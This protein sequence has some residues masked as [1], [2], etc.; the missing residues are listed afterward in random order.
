MPPHEPLFHPRTI[1]RHLANAPFPADLDERRA[2]LGVWIQR[3][4][5]GTIDR[6]TEVSTDRSFL[7]SVFGQVLDYRLFDDTR[8]LNG[9]DLDTQE[10]PGTSLRS[11][12]GAIGWFSPETSHG[13]PKLHGVIEMKRSTQDLDTA[14]G[15]SQ[16]PVEQAWGYANQSRTARWIIVSNFR[17]TRLYC[18]QRTSAEYERFLLTDLENPEAFRRFWLLLSRESLLPPDHTAASRL[19][20][21]LVESEQE[22]KTITDA[23]Y[24]DYAQ[25]R[26]EI[27]EDLK[28]AH[29]NLPQIELVRSTQKILDRF[30][31]MAFAEDRGLLPKRVI[32]RALHA[33]HDF[34]DVPVWDT[35]KALARQID[36]GDPRRDIPHLNGGLFAEDPELDALEVPDTTCLRLARLA[37]YDFGED[38]SV[39]VLGHIFEQ[40][41]SDLEQL[42]AE[43]RGESIEGVGARKKHGVFYTPGFVTRFLVEQTVGVALAERFATC[44]DEVR[45]PLDPKKPKGEQVGI[46]RLLAEREATRKL[47]VARGNDPEKSDTLKEWDAR[48]DEAWVVAWESYKRSLLRFRVLDPACGS[49]AFLAAAFDRLAT[50]YR[51]VDREISVHSKGGPLQAGLFDVDETVLQ[52]NLFGVDLSDESV[53]ISRLSLWL[54]T[55]TRQRPLTWLDGNVQRGDSIVDDPS[56]SPHAFDWHEGNRAR[57][58]FDP[59]ANPR[60][61]EIHAR[62]KDGFDVVLGNPPYVRQEWITEIKPYL[63]AHY[64]AFDGVA[65]LFVY[66]FERGLK[67]LVPGGRLGFIVANKWLKGGYAKALRG[68]LA[69][70]CDVEQVIDFGH[71]PIF[72]DA[73][74]FPS[75]IVVRKR[76]ADE[77]FDPD[78][79]V[80]AVQFPREEL[81]R[82]TVAEFVADRRFSIPQRRLG[83]DPWSLEP[84]AVELLM[85]KLRATGV[86]LT[87]WSGTRPHY[88]VKTGFNEAFLVNQSTRD[89]LVQED[90]RSAEILKPYLRGQDVQR[91][92]PDWD[93]QFILAIGSS[94]DVAW[95]WAAMAIEADARASFAATYPAVHRHMST[96]EAKLRP[97]A[98]QGRWWWELRSCTY[99]EAFTRPKI[100]YQVIQFHPRYALDHTGAFT[101]DKCFFIPGSSAWLLAVLNSPLMWW[102]NFRYLPHMKDEALTPLGVMMEKLPIAPPSTVG[103]DLADQLVPEA[104][105]L[106]KAQ[107]DASRSMVDWL[108]ASFDVEKP[109]NAL[110]DFASLNADSFLAEV[111]KRRP[112]TPRLSLGDVKQLRDTFATESDPFRARAARILAIERSISDLVLDA[113]GITP[114]ERELLIRTAPP[115][116][117]P[118]MG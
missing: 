15:R 46:D 13:A 84:P 105:A 56:V 75:I 9:W 3:L 41:I 101:N 30:L 79:T 112:R 111:T 85:G 1:A 42:R 62:W 60:A 47:V 18:R 38:V 114:E 54:K 32:E 106:S 116:M 107:H 104:V 118:G 83:T 71:A 34:L 67:Q 27:F 93:R 77:V 33:S 80:W 37:T 70:T 5:E 110:T 16:T 24:V 88:G 12:D 6:R 35:L 115:R 113:Y 81:G 94:G 19:D 31:F 8:A 11:V 55:A 10:R 117:P 21:L 45:L 90:P 7:F 36:K 74:A 96:H 78:R 98:D 65:D 87:E 44:R 48:I 99:Y 59:E 25:T 64:E 76:V 40:S 69:S 66:F 4:R 82:T 29:S 63:K 72:P 53:E 100:V 108:R 26:R 58:W 97:R 17:E 50:E 61:P 52:H 103:A 28:R 109:G 73:D 95:P 2:R 57:M 39:E 91:W 22:Q 86:P 20:A 68:L 14:G 23:L 49:G 89:R 43:A 92:A 51:R 102:H